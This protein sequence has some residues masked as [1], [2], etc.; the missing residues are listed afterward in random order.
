MNNS[1]PKQANE[2]IENTATVSRFQ[3]FQGKCFKMLSAVLP[4]ALLEQ[5]PFFYS[6]S[7]NLTLS[8][9]SPSEVSPVEQLVDLHAGYITKVA[10][11]KHGIVFTPK[12]AA[13]LLAT[14]LAPYHVEN[15]CR[16]L[17]PACG[18]GILL[19]EALSYLINTD[20]LKSF[21]EANNFLLTSIFGVDRDP[22]ATCV[23][24]FALLLTLLNHFP[25]ETLQ[26]SSVLPK[27]WSNVRCGN[28][29][30]TPEDDPKRRHG[31]IQLD[32]FTHVIG[33]PPY[34]LSRDEQ[35]QP[36]ELKLYKELYKS[37]TFGKQNKYLLFLARSI[38]LL[39]DD[40]RLSF[41]IPNSWLGIVSGKKIR[42][43][44]LEKGYIR[45]IEITSEKLFK[46]RGVETVFLTIEKKYD[47]TFLVYP[48]GEDRDE[49]FEL[50]SEAI[51]R[52]S[53]E[54]LIPMYRSKKAFRLWNTISENS[55]PLSKSELGLTPRIA[56][57]VYATGKG[58]PPQ[59]KEVVKEHRFHSEQ[60][61]SKEC[62][63]Y[64]IGKDI[65]R[66]QV[67]WSGQYLRYG[68]WVAEHQPR[69][70]YEGPRI[71]IREI[72]GKSPRL[73]QAGYIEEPAF[74]NRSIL[75]IIPNSQL[76]QETVSRRCKALLGLL[77]STVAS[78]YL[79]T[80]GRK[81]SRKLF[82]KI[83][84]GDLLDFPIP[85]EFKEQESEI[86]SL[87]DKLLDEPF[88]IEVQEKLD[89]TVADSYQVQVEDILEA[90]S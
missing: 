52:E 51:L 2:G 24:R 4:R 57:Q 19:C 49:S 43:E 62:I 66:F 78:F 7:T 48:K 60:K 54:A 59:S 20:E 84:N 39:K 90:L 70:Y 6:L 27:W 31:G 72:L 81:A 56:L 69:E 16:I 28:P 63:R 80:K 77:N 38:D 23:T 47:S 45:R 67:N 40:G 21:E 13:K 41:L 58:K 44:L 83:V 82:P 65:S 74:Y 22:V 35:I 76:S 18:S 50:Q 73:F 29:L 32:S 10:S 71:V 5:D 64:L 46:G 55:T 17:D 9:P 85:L 11:N 87:V 15:D 12:E 42:K 79:L 36:T 8:I 25:N 1:L 30:L 68:E 34:G 3:D 33:N 61:T 86:A 26:D 89:Q 14:R 53:E 37:S 88:S 75:H